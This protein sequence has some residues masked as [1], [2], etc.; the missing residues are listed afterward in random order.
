MPSTCAALT[1][2]PCLRRAA[3]FA[4]SFFSA[5]SANGAPD[6]AMA[7]PLRI[8]SARLVAVNRTIAVDS[9]TML[10]QQAPTV[11]EDCLHQAH[12]S[13]LDPTTASHTLDPLQRRRRSHKS[14]QARP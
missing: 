4:N 13:R 11:C 2:A 3:I 7:E 5:A 6:W 10:L 8:R 1:S 12:N 9:D 14:R